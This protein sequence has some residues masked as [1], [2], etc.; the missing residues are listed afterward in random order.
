[1][2]TVTV[3]SSDGFLGVLYVVRVV[4]VCVVLCIRTYLCIE[5]LGRMKRYP[6]GCSFW[7]FGFRTTYLLVLCSLKAGLRPSGGAS[8]SDSSPPALRSTSAVCTVCWSRRSPRQ[9][10]TS[11]ASFP[12]TSAYTSWASLTQGPSAE[13]HR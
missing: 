10:Q 13:P 12:T 4:C 9:E 2:G 7:I 3:E 11:L 8:L 5:A 1:M 6:N